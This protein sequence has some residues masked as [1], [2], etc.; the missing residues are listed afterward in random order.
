MSVAQKR[1]SLPQKKVTSVVLEAVRTFSGPIFQPVWPLLAIYTVDIDLWGKAVDVWFFASL[2]TIIL[3]WGSNQYLQKR[4]ASFPNKIY[5]TF[6]ESFYSRLPLLLIFLIFLAFSPYDPIIC[7]SY[8]LLFT[9]KYINQSFETLYVYEKNDW[10]SVLANVIGLGIGIAYYFIRLEEMTVIYLIFAI[11]LSEIAKSAV[12]LLL[13][14]KVFIKGK[15]DNIN[16]EMYLITYNFFIY[17]FSMI[18]IL[19]IDRFFIYTRFDASD[20]AMYQIFMNFMVFVIS[21]PNFITK[22]YHNRDKR[23]KIK[24]DNSLRMKV[25]LIGTM[26]NAAAIYASY[27]ICIHVFLL[28]VSPSFLAA[29]LLFAFPS[30]LYTPLVIYFNNKNNIG[31]LSRCAAG[32][33]IAMLTSCIFFI[34][35]FGLIGG[36]YCCILGQWIFM[37]LVTILYEQDQISKKIKLI[38]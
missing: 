25:L 29:G 4:F 30:T 12:H 22:Y 33:A 26:V 27:L 36:L 15:V 9:G 7:I 34:K 23:S 37:F 18:L 5:D 14:F 28:N 20:K 11:G 19:T 6:V 38:K 35:S 16:L 1:M 21:L 24:V 3:S 10:K 17:S 2:A 8:M 32:V 31:L 13:N